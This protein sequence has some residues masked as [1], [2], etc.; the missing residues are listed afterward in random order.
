MYVKS[1]DVWSYWRHR[2]VRPLWGSEM[3]F[4]WSF[5]K[6]SV[7]ARYVMILYAHMEVGQKCWKNAWPTY[8]LRSRFS[9]PFVI[10]VTRF[11]LFGEKAIVTKSSKCI[12]NILISVFKNP[13]IRVLFKWVVFFGLTWL[14][15]ETTSYFQIYSHD[16]SSIKQSLFSYCWM[17]HPGTKV[18]SNC[19]YYTAG[20]H[21]DAWQREHVQGYPQSTKQLLCVSLYPDR[22]HDYWH[23]NV[24]AATAR[25]HT[26]HL[27]YAACTVS[28]K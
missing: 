15:K 18:I 9:S 7:E 2:C 20:G 23:I 22:Q 6:S 25:T 1:T 27:S 8:K 28:S 14:W 17:C 19:W 26:E 10:M 11:L 13:C 5:L 3:C 12:F 4:T 24:S 16:Y 21:M